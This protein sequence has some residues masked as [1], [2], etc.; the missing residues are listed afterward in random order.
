M[1]TG[2]LPLCSYILENN[3]ACSNRTR[4]HLCVGVHCTCV[5]T[6]VVCVCVCV[7]VCVYMFVCVCV[8]VCVGGL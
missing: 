6:C 8:C 1:S 7:C 3:Y 5:Y 4:S 2:T